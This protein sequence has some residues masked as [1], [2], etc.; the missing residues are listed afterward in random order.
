MYSSIQNTLSPLLLAGARGNRV[1]LWVWNGEHAQARETYRLHAKQINALCVLDAGTMASG[2]EEKALHLWE[3][4]GGST[5]WIQQFPFP[6]TALAWSST[7]VLAVASGKN[8]FLVKR[9]GLPF[10]WVS[11]RGLVTS[12]AWSPEGKLL[13]T[14]SKDGLQIWTWFTA[15]GVARLWK[16]VDMSVASLAWSPDGLLAGEYR[17]RGMARILMFHR[18][19]ERPHTYAAHVSVVEALAWSPDST[20]IA[21]AGSSML[22]VWDQTSRECLWTGECPEI[23]SLAWS[24]NGIWLATNSRQG[25]QIWESGTGLLWMTLPPDRQDDLP[26]P[27]VWVG[28][29]STIDTYE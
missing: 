2:G 17:P 4:Q 26:G 9:N 5:Q 19:I 1:T 28:S 22:R 23:S 11:H 29:S 20:R 24:P 12:V 3:R 10:Q 14:G 8:I 25:V 18:D 27:V 21:S 13:A 7:G 15:T 6:I 16:E